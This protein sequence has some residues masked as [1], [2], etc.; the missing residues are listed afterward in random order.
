MRVLVL[1]LRLSA[2]LPPGFWARQMA[3][4]HYS[5]L[6]FSLS[7]C[8]PAW[9]PTVQ[10]FLF[11]RSMETLS[12]ASSQSVVGGAGSRAGRAARLMPLSADATPGRGGRGGG[13]SLFSQMTAVLNQINIVINIIYGDG[14]VSVNQTNLGLIGM[15][16]LG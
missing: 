8:L 10:A 3:W 16:V 12:D 2:Q 15:S 14:M 1:L 4:L 5:A 13:R 6:L 9:T 7:D 11:L